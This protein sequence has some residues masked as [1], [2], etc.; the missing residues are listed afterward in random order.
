MSRTRFNWERSRTSKETRSAIDVLHFVS[1]YRAKTL[2]SDPGTSL[3]NA[4][5]QYLKRSRRHVLKPGTP[6]HR[7]TAEHRKTPEHW[8]TSE[9][10]N[11]P[12]HPK[13]PAQPKEEEWKSCHVMTNQPISA[14]LSHAHLHV[15]FLCSDEPLTTMAKSVRG[16]LSESSKINQSVHSSV[17]LIHMYFYFVF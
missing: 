15:L 16:N 9:H 3:T 17:M 5:L 11:T 12:E 10:R 4:C 6:E 13:T 8:N 14:Q 2:F 7:N 1:E